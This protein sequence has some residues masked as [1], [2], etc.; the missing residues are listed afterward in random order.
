[1]HYYQHH[2]GDFIKA[3]ARLSDSQTIAYLRLLWMYYDT[4]KPLI[5]DTE[6]LAFQIGTSIQDTEL[7]LRTF[8]ILT[9]KG[10]KQTRC[11]EEIS[12]YREFLNKKSMAGRASA[13]QRKNT[14]STPVQQTLNDSSTD[15]Q[16]TNNHKPITN[17]NIYNDQF[18]MFWKSYPKK[19]AK[20]SAKKAWIKIKPNDELIAKI[21][22]AVKDQKLSERE[23]QFIPHAA[24]WL[25]AKRW[26]DEIAGTTQKPLMGWK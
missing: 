2:I 20:E 18:E 1:M 3:T 22:K 10:W 9:D 16:L 15:V 14:R 6:L 4:E 25:N 8:F 5:L 23:Q 11:E 12:S 24:T 7:L 17:I 21:T 19:T 26:E 13:E